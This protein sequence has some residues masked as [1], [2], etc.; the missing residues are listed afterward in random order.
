MP[1]EYSLASDVAVDAALRLKVEQD[2][3]FRETPEIYLRL[4]DEASGQSWP[5]P[6]A[7]VSQA[8]TYE[9]PGGPRTERMSVAGTRERARME[10]LFEGLKAAHR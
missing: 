6:V 9:T 4:S 1:F 7:V 8:V 2:L 10:P 5:F 3:S